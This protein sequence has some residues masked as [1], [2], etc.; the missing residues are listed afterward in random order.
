MKALLPVFCRPLGYVIL[1]ISMFI[2]FLLLMQGMVTDSNLLFYKEGIKLLMILGAMM[3]IF[4]LSRNEGRETEIIRNKATRNAIFLT[5]LFLFGGML[6][7][8]ATGDIM[9]VD[10]SSFLIFLIINVL[11]LEFGMQKARI[12]KIF[13]R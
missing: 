11:C 6:Y 9:T 1:V 13:K 12:D 5:V 2:P 10:T 7:R 3:I 4:A 8:V